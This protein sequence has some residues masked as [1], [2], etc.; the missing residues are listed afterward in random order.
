M[1]LVRQG[2]GYAHLEKIVATGG[3]ETGS[4]RGNHMGVTRYLAECQDDVAA[5][6]LLEPGAGRQSIDLDQ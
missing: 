3:I 4:S 6:L 2:R 5:R 1:L